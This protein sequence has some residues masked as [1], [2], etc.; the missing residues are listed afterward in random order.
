MAIELAKAYNGEV[1][2]CDSM[3]IYRRMDIGTAKPT[4]E[5]MEDIP[6]HM[7]DVAEPDEPFS[8]SRYVEM[9]DPILQDILSR[10][11]RCIVCGGTGLYVDS[12][13]A[14]RTF[15]PMPET[16]KRQELEQLAEKAKFSQ[17]A[18]SREELE[19]FRRELEEGQKELHSAPW[20]RKMV[21]RYWFAAW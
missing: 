3:Q 19:V 2:S 4:A 9:A 8:V 14:G 12:L 13:M 15:A 1:L 16:G 11:K 20:Y 10:G 6:H 21:Y 7:I 18:L 5:E 17:Y